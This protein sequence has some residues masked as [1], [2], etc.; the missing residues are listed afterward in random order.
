[1]ARSFSPARRLR[2]WGKAR[3]HVDVS[4]DRGVTDR[5]V[6]RRCAGFGKGWRPARF[7][8]NLPQKRPAD[9]ARET[10]P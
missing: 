2:Q 6:R 5:R 1:M 3:D 7:R 9:V 4:E 10:R 8:G